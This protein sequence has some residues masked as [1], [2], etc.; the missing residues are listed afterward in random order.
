MERAP[1]FDDPEFVRS[2]FEREDGLQE[3]A[4]AWQKH[5][6]GPDLT[7][8]VL[9][10]IAPLRPSRVLEVGAG[11]GEFARLMADDFGAKVTAID[12]SARMAELTRLRGVEALEADVQDLP[13]ADGSFDMVVANYVLFLVADL[14]EALAEIARVL[15][16]DGCLVAATQT[17]RSLPEL[18]ELLGEP[19]TTP[20]SFSSENGS[21]V[22][23]PWFAQVEERH[24]E[25]VLTFSDTRSIRDFVA[26]SLNRGHLASRVPERSVP[27]RAATRDTVFVA[28]GPKRPG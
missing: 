12:R 4:A 23:E 21:G 10:A 8:F 2:S 17:E 7:E 24:V 5:R 13:F 28:R 15:D 26:I 6:Q 3:R 19:V 16:D 27:L 22:L 18:W 11:T 25:A 20:W 9:S 14:G 1:H